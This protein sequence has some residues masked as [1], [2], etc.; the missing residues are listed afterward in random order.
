MEIAMSNRFF[1][2]ALLCGSALFATQESNASIQGRYYLTSVSGQLTVV[3]GTNVVQSWTIPYNA[4]PIA[5]LDGKVNTVGYYGS[6][7]GAEFTTAGVPTGNTYFG[8][9]YYAFDGTTDGTYNYAYNSNFGGMF[10]F[11]LNWQNPTLLFSGPGG[12]LG[13]TYDPTNNSLW[14]ADWGDQTIRNVDMSGILL[15]SFN[16][17]VFYMGALALDHSDGT[18]WFSSLNSSDTGLYQ[19]SKTGQLLD[20]VYVAGLESDY[21]YGGEFELVTSAAPPAVPEPTTMLVWLGLSAIGAS[22]AAKRLRQT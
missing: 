4:S 18:L 16:T 13:V 10:R 8:G 22:V 14:I 15:S 19:Y 11:D 12:E 21:H 9:I 1:I 6:S 5:V 20:T 7:P 2:A 3:Q 17:S